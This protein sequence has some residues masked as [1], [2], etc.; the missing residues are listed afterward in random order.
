MALKRG[1]VEIIIRDTTGKH[2]N[3]T[4]LRIA[5]ISSQALT[6]TATEKHAPVSVNP[7]SAELVYKDRTKFNIEMHDRLYY[8]STFNNLRI[9]NISFGKTKRKQQQQR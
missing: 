4:F 8:L 2:V 9:E 3:A 1:D 6:L 5:R 7:D